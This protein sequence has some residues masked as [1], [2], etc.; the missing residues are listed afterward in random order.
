MAKISHTQRQTHSLSQK[1]SMRQIHALNMLRMSNKDLAEEIQKLL[2]ENP[3]LEIAP[4]KKEYKRTISSDSLQSALEN[5]EARTESLQEHLLHQINAMNL[6]TEENYL[7]RQLI[8]N[9]DKNGCYG[10]MIAPQTFLDKTN[11]LHTPELLKKCIQTIQKLDPVGTCCKTLE[12]SLY[13]QAQL[14]E[15]PPTLALFILNGN[16]D[17]LNPPQISVIQKKLIKYRQN[18]HKKSFAPQIILDDLPLSEEEITETINFIRTLNPRPA[19]GFSHDTSSE[20]S[21]PDIVLIIEKKEGFI[22]Q[23]NY[24]NG[25]IATQENYHFQI[26]YTSGLI[27]DIRISKKFENV[28]NTQN[29]ATNTPNTETNNELY[30]KSLTEAKNLISNLQFRESTIVLQGCAI[31]KNQL[32]FF[33]NGPGHIK[34]LTHKQIAEQL[35]INESTVSRVAN[36]NNSKFFQTPWGILPASYFFSSGIQNSNNQKTSA[37]EIKTKIEKLISQK[38]QK[39]LSDSDIT[40]LLNEEGILI[41]RRTVAKYRSQLGLQNSYTR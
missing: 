23:D 35:Q 37:E 15:N 6:S 30:N 22:A 1:I 14:T 11:P 32:D 5:T 9:L 38:Q 25:L 33:I 36:K 8:Y 29:D 12:E 41:S 16:L 31:V 2:D 4:S 34:P 21:E 40:K 10:S 26:K 24:E 27:P 20:F 3:A 17:F 19:Q 18:W 39:N 7:C 28:F 13:I